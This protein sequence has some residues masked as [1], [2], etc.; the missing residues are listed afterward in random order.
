MLLRV[1]YFVLFTGPAGRGTRCLEG[2]LCLPGN[3]WLIIPPFAFVLVDLYSHLEGVFLG[4]IALVLCV[5]INWWGK[6]QFWMWI[7]KGAPD[8]RRKKAKAIEH[9]HLVLFPDCGFSVINSLSLLAL[10]L[11]GHDRLYLLI[12]S[13]S[14]PFFPSLLYHSVTA[15][16]KAML[17]I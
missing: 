13:Q 3:S 4:V 5:T 8:W 6:S 11:L 7:R 15:A 12:V 14:R 9:Q 1:V 16:R 17:Y 2:L 10:S